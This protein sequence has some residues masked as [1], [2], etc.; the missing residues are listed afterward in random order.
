M[1]GT[2]VLGLALA[3][4]GLVSVAATEPHAA[5]VAWVFETAMERSV[6][7]H[8]SGISAPPLAEAGRLR[9]G[10]RAYNAICVGCHGAPGVEPAA[11]AEGLLPPP[12]ELEHAA[13][14]WSPEELFWI[15]KHGVRMTG[16]PGFGSTHEDDALWDV[17][18]FLRELPAPTPQQYAALRERAAAPEAAGTEGDAGGSDEGHE[19][20]T[21]EHGPRG[22]SAPGAPH[23]APRSRGSPAERVRPASPVRA[24]PARGCARARA[25]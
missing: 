13:E 3:W 14:E 1:L 4:G 19:H 9:R 23:P 12:P 2:A 10:F 18:A 16:M 5:P 15:T 8:A 7:R 17:V 6:R 22:A 21:H 20:G 25:H 24:L 11:L